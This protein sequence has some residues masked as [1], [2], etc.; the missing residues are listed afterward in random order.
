MEN[1]I[2]RDINT[3]LD[4]NGPILSITQ[5]PGIATGIGTT[6]IRSS[7]TGISSAS[8]NWQQRTVPA[9]ES[10]WAV[11]NNA[12][13][14]GN[15]LFVTA[16]SEGYIATSPDSITWTLTPQIDGDSNLNWWSGA[17]GNG[18]FV[19]VGQRVNDTT[20]IAASST[21][22][23]N[24]TLVTVTEA[25]PAQIL[26]SVASDGSKFVAG[27][28]DPGDGSNLVT[29]TDG[30]TWSAIADTVA[31]NNDIFW[32]NG[33]WISMRAYGSYSR[34]IDG[35][36][37]V[38][39]TVPGG[40]AG[41]S[42]VAYG[43][44]NLSNNALWIMMIGT[45]IIAHSTDNALTWT[46]SHLSV[47][48]VATYGIR[49]IVY[50][51]SGWIAG[52]A[53]EGGSTG[54]L[55]V[56]EDGYNWTYPNSNYKDLFDFSVY[57]VLYANGYYVAQ[58]DKQIASA[59]IPMD[60]DDD[61]KWA[62]PAN[63]KLLP[64][65]GG[66]P[67]TPSLGSIKV[68]QDESNTFYIWQSTIAPVA[69]RTYFKKSV[70]GGETWTDISNIDHRIR[71]INSWDV[72]NDVVIILTDQ[73]EPTARAFRSADGCQSWNM[74]DL[75]SIIEDI[76]P[77]H[78]YTPNDL[79][80]GD[81]TN[82]N[83]L[84]NNT[85]MIPI[86]EQGI[87]LVSTDNGITWSNITAVGVTTSAGPFGGPSFYTDRGRYGMIGRPSAISP[88]VWTGTSPDNLDT[89]FNMSIAGS[90]DRWPPTVAYSFLG[91]GVLVAASPYYWWISEDDGQ[92]W[93]V[94]SPIVGKGH[95]DPSND[96][97]TQITSINGVFFAANESVH[98]SAALTQ[99]NECFWYSTD[100]GTNWIYQ[101]SAKHAMGSIVCSSSG[102]YA[103]FTGVGTDGTSYLQTATIP[104]D[105][106]VPA[107]S[108]SLI[109]IATAT[110]TPTGIASN[111]GTIVYQWYKEGVPMSDSTYITGTATTTLTISPL[112]TPSDQAQYYFTADYV[113]TY[114]GVGDPRIGSGY[115]TGNA[116]NEPIQSGI[117]TINVIPLIEIISQPSSLQIDPDQE[118]T[119]NVLATLTD[120]RYA[121]DL[122]Y[123]WV[124]DGVEVNDGTFVTDGDGAS[125]TQTIQQTFTSD[126]S[127]TIPAGATDV[128]I[129]LA[130][131]SGGHG[132]SGDST[133]GN[134]GLG[135]N[136]RIG[137]FT[138]LSTEIERT[139]HF[140]IGNV[141]NG[142]T[143]QNNA[144]QIGGVFQN[145][146]LGGSSVVGAGGGGGNSSFNAN[147]VA[148]G[149][150]GGGGATG[151]RDPDLGTDYIAIAGGGG[152]GGGDGGSIGNAPDAQGTINGD[153]TPF[154]NGSQQVLL[155]G[156]HGTGG[157]QGLPGGGGGGGGADLNVILPETGQAHNGGAGGSGD[158]GAYGFSGT[159]A[160][161]N[162]QVSLNDEDTNYGNG[163]AHVSYVGEG[164]FTTRN[165]IISGSKTPTLTISSDT[166]GV[167]TVRCKISSATASNSPQYTNLVNYAVLGQVDDAMLCIEEISNSTTAGLVEV[168]LRNGPYT[169][170]TGDLNN[171]SS[172][173]THTYV[174][175]AK[176]NY[177][178]G[179]HL[180]VDIDL[181]GGM[182]TE[183]RIRGADGEWYTTPGAEG[184][185]SRV[186]LIMKQGRE[187]V[188]TG[189]IAGV[190][191]P[192]LYEMGRLI[193][194]VGEGGHFGGGN[195]GGVGFAGEASP[196]GAPGAVGG[197][198][199]VQLETNG[200][201][202][203]NFVSPLLQEGDTQA[204]GR[205]GG[206]TLRCT[207]GNW[208]ATQIVDPCGQNPPG[209]YPSGDAHS[210]YFRL[211]NGD[212]VTNTSNGLARG[213]KSG[214]N[215]MQTA[216]AGD[217]A[218]VDWWGSGAQAGGRGGNGAWGGQ[219][220]TVNNGGGG[221]SGYV[222]ESETDPWNPPSVGG[223]KVISSQRGGSTFTHARAVVTLVRVIN[224]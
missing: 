55:I 68:K 64:P 107:P 120:N 70:D 37:W 171:T 75:E 155:A 133:T 168:N 8:A 96:M 105:I 142:G 109:G 100:G 14:Y 108:A 201:F 169:F 71:Y 23:I 17:F 9:G 65:P 128:R 198:S 97:P 63:W 6:S 206:R 150:G 59:T 124:I 93:G 62:G 174:L 11:N 112:I 183:R 22:G 146:G 199:G 203:S 138:L 83:Y 187:Y 110:F 51:P 164:D 152:G 31:G 99:H 56:S 193:A 67:V 19:I 173:T 179:R 194:V 151:F 175:Y 177:G 180:E 117:G 149:G 73:G 165:M 61:G 136:G 154:R 115:R 166:V 205:N 220:G 39:Y 118:V 76:T 88:H 192:F 157:G 47:D 89:S 103:A 26:T 20:P 32:G 221:G 84:G 102:T 72:N 53:G 204:T 95:N 223:L 27:G 42:P 181:Y 148:G 139:L 86:N 147:L 222:V 45:N 79:G 58:G 140:D 153:G 24:W 2:F 158:T 21:D 218:W 161:D 143:S 111:Q 36:T 81:L 127:C 116:P 144:D 101:A 12:L 123:Q 38:D 52:S 213:F 188:I 196:T 208:W 209:Y 197:A 94:F 4:L 216:G 214:Y 74:I 126:G 16:G 87:G 212:E 200:I 33:V 210:G 185:K 29:S 5:Q 137:V 80:S 46:V 189:L 130:G 82:L 224:E 170:S 172:E 162:R 98:S 90:T 114:S 35:V 215:V 49:D 184:G 202:G 13:M 131:A 190:N 91:G 135:G 141:G 78:Q 44:D 195:G 15:D 40:D 60:V 18:R 121:D 129:N 43:R 69:P 186:R 10:G 159:S 106:I 191:T 122:Q 219:G 156:R 92:T 41:S 28:N 57:G 178:G 182:G 50:G 134:G 77:D 163:Y 211:P 119:F 1:Q 30:I 176:G 217:P 104:Y 7:N 25:A 125:S 54:F 113:P 48:G 160:F 34:S 66:T 167:S 85:W 3:G 132:G 207:K 145:G